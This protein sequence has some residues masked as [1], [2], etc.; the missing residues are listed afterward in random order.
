[1]TLGLVLIVAAL[2]TG[3]WELRRLDHDVQALRTEAEGGASTE[4]RLDNALK[5]LAAL[6][7]QTAKVRES[8]IRQEF[9]AFVYAYETQLVAAVETGYSEC[10]AAKRSWESYVNDTLIP[11]LNKRENRDVKLAVQHADSDYHATL[12]NAPSIPC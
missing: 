9:Y 3:A 7:K 4:S 5:S 1:V 8:G 12:L 11:Y 10:G 6:S 2:A